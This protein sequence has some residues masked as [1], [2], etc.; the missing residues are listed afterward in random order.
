MN[1]C[2]KRTPLNEW[3]RAHGARMVEFGG[4]DMPVQY[5]PG[6]LAEHLATRKYGGLFD[7]SHM[8]RFA[9]SGAGAVAF[10]QR[11]L[12]NDVEAL[13]PWCAQYT[14][15]PN[16]QG[17]VIDDAYLYRR[18]GNEYLLVVNASNREKDWAHLCRHAADT[19]DV[20]LEDL[21]DRTA[22]I[23]FQ[24]PSAESILRESVERGEFPD[25]PRNAVSEVEM[26]GAVVLVARTGY[27]GEPVCFELFAPAGEIGSI[28]SRLYEAGREG[29][30][31]PVGLGAR[32]TLRLE[33]GMPLYGHEFGADP[34]GNEIPALA[35]PLAGIA[36]SFSASKGAYV[37]RAA[38][39]K[40]A[41]EVRRI[42]EGGK[43]SDVLPRRVRRL[44]ILDRGI[45]RHG[46][47]VL[48]SGKKI[49]VI[50]SGT[51]TPYW[52]FTGDDGNGEIGDQSGRRTIAL[53]Y[54]D[55]ALKPGQRLE[56]AVRK[57]LL[58]GEIVK[59]FGR[60]NAAP[61]FRPIVHPGH[62]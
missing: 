4:W 33:A 47:E 39:A 7:V 41:D 53:A 14:L 34:A 26:C 31:L 32:D 10:L 17:G 27:T 16:E 3:H 61:W 12:S 37:G 36:V 28:W 18:E 29:G 21:T 62:V 55:A 49:G 13:D 22:M 54:L 58:Q 59:S 44:A 23:A 6:I 38:L 42:R 52:S 40:Q 15:I 56:I 1:D 2:L 8:G 35:V 46:D 25:A 9:V 50:T 24:G 45:A 11:V 43:P 30:V 60:S 51:T 5:S 48:L 19:V 57:R 20:L